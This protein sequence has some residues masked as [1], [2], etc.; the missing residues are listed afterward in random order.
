VQNRFSV[1]KDNN[2]DEVI[3]FCEAHT[4]AYLPWNPV[5]GRGDAPHLDTISL[6]LGDIGRSHDVSPHVIAIAWLLQRSKMMLPIPGTRYFDHVKEN[7]EASNIELTEHELE[8][9]N[10][11]WERIA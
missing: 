7:M 5:G 1:L 2:Q 6:T 9:L 3:A 10:K 4:M 8:R 11:E